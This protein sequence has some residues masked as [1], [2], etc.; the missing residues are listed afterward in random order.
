L[1]KSLDEFTQAYIEAALWSST[2]QSDDQGG[3]PLDKNY[4]VEDIAEESMKKIREDCVKFQEKHADLISE[5][6]SRAGHDFW[7]TR[8]RHGAGYWDGDWPEEAGKTLTEA[9][10]TYGEVNIV[11]GDDGKLHF[12]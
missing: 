9:A 12:C 4:S 11:V 1:L 10:H 6:L 5:D 7:L 8:A 2:D 3:E